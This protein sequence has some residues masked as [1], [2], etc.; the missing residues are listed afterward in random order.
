M[1][2]V[3]TSLGIAGSLMLIICLLPVQIVIHYERNKE[4]NHVEIGFSTL[5][6]LIRYAVELPVVDLIMTSNKQFQIRAKVKSGIG[7]KKRK[8]RPWVTLAVE[9][10]RKAFEIQQSLVEKLHNFMPHLRSLSKIFRIQYLKWETEIGIGD[11]ALTGTAA[12]LVW[13]VKGT[14]I[15]ILSHVFTL[16]VKPM[17]RVSPTFHQTVF[18]TRLDCI[19]RFWVGQ[20]IFEGIKMAIYLLREGKRPWR[21]IRSKV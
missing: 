8:Q 21:I 2:W 1:D 14:V 19:I 13:S 16:H 7:D 11:A 20:A 5:F 12:G 18:A 9:Q 15:G 3:W 10:I 17:I 6:G 4:K